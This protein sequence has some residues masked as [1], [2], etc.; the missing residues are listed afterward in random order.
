MK[1]NKSSENSNQS[2]IPVDVH[3]GRAAMIGFVLAFCSYLSVD[4]LSPGMV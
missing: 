4:V 1:S 3:L 2:N